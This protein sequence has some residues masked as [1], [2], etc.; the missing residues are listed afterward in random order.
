MKRYPTVLTIAGSDCSGGAG[1]QADIKTITMNGCYAAA[2]ITA[3]TAQNTQAVYQIEIPSLTFMEAQLNAVF[4]DI[5]ID[6]VKIGM[7]SDVQT[8]KCVSDYLTRYQPKH[9]VL[10]PVMIAQSNVVLVSDEVMQVAQR[11]LFPLTTLITPNVPEAEALSGQSIAVQRDMETVAQQLGSQH[12]TNVL[13]KGGH[14]DNEDFC[15]DVLYEY[16]SA[17]CHWFSARRTVSDNVHGTGCALSSAIAA[18]LAKGAALTAAITQAK[19]YLS[20]AIE[21]GKDY[22]VGQGSGPINHFFCLGLDSFEINELPKKD[23]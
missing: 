20:N 6:A 15:H 23:P 17:R 12:N 10:D 1:I 18:F 2:V 3:L 16:Q 14:L 5:K 8:L 22:R 7:I 13:V 11:R 9:I 19:Q 21:Y 4:S